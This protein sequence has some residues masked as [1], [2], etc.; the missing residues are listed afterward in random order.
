ML[1]TKNRRCCI[2]TLNKYSF[3]TKTR[4]F[5]HLVPLNLCHTHS[6]LSSTAGWERARW[7]LK[8]QT[9]LF[10]SRNSGS[11]FSS[12]TSTHTQQLGYRFSPSHVLMRSSH[13]APWNS[14][15][16]VRSHPQ[17]LQG[18]CRTSGQPSTAPELATASFFQLPQTE[19]LLGGQTAP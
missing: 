2:Y 6:L 18:L 13:F 17:T 7:Q 15:G 8:I 4:H 1:D 5:L 19:L 10:P 16:G 9:L 3:R 11:Q 12:P 14:P